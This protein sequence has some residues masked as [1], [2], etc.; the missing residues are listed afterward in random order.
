[1]GCDFM[2]AITARFHILYILVLLEIGRRRIVHCNVT[3]HHTADWT[4]QQLREAYR[5][6]MRIA[7]CFMIATPPF[8]LNWIKRS[9]IS[10]LGA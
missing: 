3:A 7:F 9:K 1:M 8:L 10:E 6:S 5:A 4:M 2:V